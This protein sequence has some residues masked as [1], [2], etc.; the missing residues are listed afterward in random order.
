MVL[1]E[2]GPLNARY[3]RTLNR[4]LLGDRSTNALS[5]NFDIL[6]TFLFSSLLLYYSLLLV[7]SPKILLELALGHAKVDSLRGRA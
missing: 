4:L 5:N 1:G 3:N 2:A 7:A 6:I